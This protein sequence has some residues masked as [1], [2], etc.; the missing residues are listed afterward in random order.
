MSASM[1]SHIT[2]E[3]T[4]FI[5]V[6]LVN[7]CFTELCKIIYTRKDGR[8][9]TNY[10]YDEQIWNEIFNRHHHLFE[11]YFLIS[12]HDVII[13]RKTIAVFTHNTLAEY[14]DNLFSSYKNKKKNI[15]IYNVLHNANE[16]N[17]LFEKHRVEMGKRELKNH[18]IYLINL[19]VV[20]QKRDMIEEFLLMTED[21]RSD[22][23]N[24]ININIMEYF[25]YIARKGLSVQE[26]DDNT[27]KQEEDQDNMS[28]VSFQVLENKVFGI[29]HKKLL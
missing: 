23:D 8:D 11:Y 13:S 2:E 18:L 14:L 25:D 19:Y 16:Y 6:F 29:I 28:N 10:L 4:R 22:I 12:Q 27:Y 5:K 20:Y 7:C 15:Y 17:K 21:E 1:F 3:Y 9:L 26:I 24:N